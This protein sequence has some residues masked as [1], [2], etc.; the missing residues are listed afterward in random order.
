MPQASLIGQRCARC[1]RHTIYHI[2][3]SVKYQ[4]LNIPVNSREDTFL[5]F[6]QNVNKTFHLL[7][8]ISNE[9]QQQHEEHTSDFLI[10]PR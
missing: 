2:A 10:Y 6:I 7:D 4:V 3:Q 9:T 5:S 1:C 8:H